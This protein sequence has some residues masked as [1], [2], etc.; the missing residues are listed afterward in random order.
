MHLLC[1]WVDVEEDTEENIQKRIRNEL[2]YKGFDRFVSNYS[3]YYVP[4]RLVCNSICSVC[5]EINS[6]LEKYI[7]YCTLFYKKK[8]QYEVKK[9][10]RRKFY[11]EKYD[12]K[13]KEL[14]NG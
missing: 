5:G 10:E 13:V 3:E 9:E 1:K 6:T 8:V 11:K 14:Q 7:R 4:D 2:G 12:K